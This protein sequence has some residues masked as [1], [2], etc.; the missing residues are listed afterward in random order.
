MIF[1]TMYVVPE[2]SIRPFLH[3]TQERFPAFLDEISPTNGTE[4]MKRLCELDAYFGLLR[5]LWGE[6]GEKKARQ[7]VC[8]LL[9]IFLNHVARYQFNSIERN[10]KFAT[11]LLQLMD[12]LHVRIECPRDGCQKPAR[13]GLRRAGRT[14]YGSFMFEHLIGKKQVIHFTAATLPE[15]LKLIPAPP[16]R[17][18][19]RHRT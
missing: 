17:R 5:M 9:Q 6:K 1:D 2:G 16:D 11:E 7:E 15:A 14:C 10:H 3:L 4:M 19:T 12:R 18:S 13:I 8:S